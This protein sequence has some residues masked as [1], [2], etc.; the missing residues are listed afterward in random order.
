MDI[1]KRMSS[2]YAEAKKLAI[3]GNSLI[4]KSDRINFRTVHGHLAISV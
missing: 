4:S 1:I 3:E 2:E